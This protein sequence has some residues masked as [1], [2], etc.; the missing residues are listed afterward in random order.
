VAEKSGQLQLLSTL[1][2]LAAHHLAGL[3]HHA[4]HVRLLGTVQQSAFIYL[5]AFVSKVPEVYILRK[6][7]IM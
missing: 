4:S 3:W 6:N 2:V 1:L 5:K 7:Q